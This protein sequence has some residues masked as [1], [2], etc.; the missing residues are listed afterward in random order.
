M[1]LKVWKHGLRLLKP[2]RKNCE[3][4][5]P[6]A[7]E[8]A[9][10]DS[11]SDPCR[12][13]SIIW[14]QY[15][16][17]SCPLSNLFCSLLYPKALCFL[18]VQEEM[19]A[20]TRVLHIL[21][22]WGPKSLH[23]TRVPYTTPFPFHSVLYGPASSPRLFQKLPEPFPVFGRDSTCYPIS[24]PMQLIFLWSLIFLPHHFY[25]FSFSLEDLR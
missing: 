16:N 2:L 6:I 17:L 3:N 9:V 24:S 20:S 15:V 14:F 11:S 8:S 4:E 19:V 21:L 5:G 13:N 23:I 12:T 25:F 10:T 22:L 18:N 7:N 1:L